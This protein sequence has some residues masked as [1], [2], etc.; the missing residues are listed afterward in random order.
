MILFKINY[1]LSNYNFLLLCSGERV[2]YSG[3][4]LVTSLNGE[5]EGGVVVEAVGLDKCNLYQEEATSGNNGQFRIRG[6]QPGVCIYV[7]HF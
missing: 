1:Y 4:G 6:L 7:M 3:H 2:A 5:G